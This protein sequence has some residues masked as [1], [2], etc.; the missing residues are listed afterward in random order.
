MYSEF[1]YIAEWFYP[2]SE[3]WSL[4]SRK[5]QVRRRAELVEVIFGDEAE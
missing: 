2:L 5:A 4:M 1:S 3:S